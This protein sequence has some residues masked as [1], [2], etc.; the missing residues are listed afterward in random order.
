MASSESYRCPVCNSRHGIPTD[1][2]GQHE[3]WYWL[4]DPYFAGPFCSPNC[5][6]VFTQLATL[7]GLDAANELLRLREHGQDS[8]AEDHTDHTWRWERML[9][10]HR[11][12]VE[13]DGQFVPLADSPDAAWRLI[14]C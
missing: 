8:S 9:V 6:K 10:S 7:H 14:L 2:D 5:T 13:V 1:D 4:R 12:P 11:I 3:D